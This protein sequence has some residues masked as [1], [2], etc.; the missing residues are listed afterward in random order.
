MINTDY[1]QYQALA[2]LVVNDAIKQ[3]KA[4]LEAEKLEQVKQKIFTP[5][6]VETTDDE[7]N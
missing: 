6:I 7:T 1:A 2:D 5:V 3:S 4:Q